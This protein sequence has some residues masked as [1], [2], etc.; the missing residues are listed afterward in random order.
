MSISSRKWIVVSYISE[1]EHIGPKGR[2]PY[3]FKQESDWLSIE[4][5]SQELDKIMDRIIETGE[6]EQ[7]RVYTIVSDKDLEKRP[8]FDGI[9][10]KE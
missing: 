4:G 1:R 2:K 5:A 9:Y 8:Y 7:Y 3:G 10:L 6:K